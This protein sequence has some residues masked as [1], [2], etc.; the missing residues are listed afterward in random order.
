MPVSITTDYGTFTGSTIGEAQKAERKAR[1]LAEKERSRV[2]ALRNVARQRAEA[3]AFR[4]VRWKLRDQETPRGWR[5]YPYG[6]TGIYSCNRIAGQDYDDDT[7]KI[8]TSDGTGSMSVYRNTF[9]GHVEN[10]AG[11]TIAILLRD[12]DGKERIF[13]VGTHEG[14]ATCELIP[15]YTRSD[16]R[17]TMR[18]ESQVA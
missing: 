6:L 12:G 17:L 10:G 3:E 4:I 11:F 5:F 8:E 7:L 18:A 16:F 2:E 13:A 15:G 9:I 14:V 1:K